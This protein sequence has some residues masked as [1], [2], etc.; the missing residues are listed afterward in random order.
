MAEFNFTLKHKPDK[1]LV[2]PD[3]LNRAP[4]PEPSTIGDNLAVFPAHVAASFVTRLGYDIPF[5]N[6]SL[7]GEVF[8]DAVYPSITLY[9]P[10]GLFVRIFITH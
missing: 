1:E 7:V 10:C 9:K 8:N 2:V 6:P 3:K 4:L 5:L